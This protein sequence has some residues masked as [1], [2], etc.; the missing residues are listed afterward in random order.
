MKYEIIIDKT[1]L[2]FISKQP[3]KE[4]ERILKAISR[5]PDGDTIKMSGRFNMHRLR[6]GTYRIIFMIK[7]DK[8][9]IRVVEAGNRGDIYK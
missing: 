8:L 7:Q 4:A 6:V 5:L 3:K 9:I 1:A 2:K